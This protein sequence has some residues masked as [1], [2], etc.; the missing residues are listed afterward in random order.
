MCSKRS[1]IAKSRSLKRTSKTDFTAHVA[2]RDSSTRWTKK[3]MGGVSPSTCRFAVLARVPRNMYNKHCNAN[4]SRSIAS[5][6]VVSPM[7]WPRLATE[8]PTSLRSLG[9]VFRAEYNTVVKRVSGGRNSVGQTSGKSW[10]NPTSPSCSLVS[11]SQLGSPTTTATVQSSRTALG[12][13]GAHAVGVVLLFVYVNVNRKRVA[14]K[15]APLLTK[16]I[17]VPWKPQRSLGAL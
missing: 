12:F 14:L 17:H 10:K 5:H 7:V 2:V 15:D 13:S 9:F 11:H 6:D 4:I 1:C 3:V 8:V 16:S